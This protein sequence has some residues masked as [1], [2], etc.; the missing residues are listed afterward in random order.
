MNGAFKVFS[1]RRRASCQI[2]GTWP[3]LENLMATSVEITFPSPDQRSLPK[4]VH[5][6]FFERPIN[7]LN[8]HNI[9]INML[10]LFCFTHVFLDLYTT[11]PPTAISTMGSLSLT[12][13]ALRPSLSCRAWG[14]RIARRAEALPLITLQEFRGTRAPSCSEMQRWPKWESQVRKFQRAARKR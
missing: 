12:E 10:M 14:G 5:R 4:G 3:D 11:G 13:D 9:H 6:D 2:D 7:Q 1:R 8:V